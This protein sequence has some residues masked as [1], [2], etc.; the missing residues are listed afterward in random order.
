MN[1]KAEKFLEKSGKWQEEMNLLAEI[2]RT[3]TSLEEDFKWKHPTYTYKGKNIVLIHSFK[4]YCALLFPKGVLLKDPKKLLVRQTKNVQAA[5][6]LRFTT[7]AEIKKQQ[8][9]IKAYVREA[10]KL[11]DQGEAVKMKKTADSETPEELTAAFKA[12]PA[13]KKAFYALTPGRQRGYLLH[14]SQAKQAGTRI[15]RI[16]KATPDIMQGIGKDDK[17]QSK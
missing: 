15:S 8:A 14:F 2:I 11:E 12:N 6:Q 10:I 4:E 3:N 17:Y 9:T 5:R 7:L 13:L 1:T 16:K